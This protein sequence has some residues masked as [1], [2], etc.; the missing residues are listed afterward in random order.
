LQLVG[1]LFCEEKQ[2]VS[3]SRLGRQYLECGNLAR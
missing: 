1:H 3:S 2:G